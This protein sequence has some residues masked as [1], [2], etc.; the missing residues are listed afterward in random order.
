VLL[1]QGDADEIVDPDAAARWLQ[2]IG[3]PDVTHRLLAG[4]R[5][6]LISEPGWEQTAAHLLDWLDARCAPA[7]P[8]HRAA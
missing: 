7:L 6:E 3:S 5:H 4:A 1:L 8:Q 2:K